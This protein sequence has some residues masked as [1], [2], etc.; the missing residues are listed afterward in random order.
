[1][2]AEPYDNMDTLSPVLTLSESQFSIM[3]IKDKNTP[4]LGLK[5]ECNK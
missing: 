5:Y 2:L 1:M 4:P 3:S